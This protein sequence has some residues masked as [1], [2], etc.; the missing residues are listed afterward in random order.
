MVASR[1][2]WKVEEILLLKRE[3]KVHAQEDLTF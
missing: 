3:R 2:S 1:E